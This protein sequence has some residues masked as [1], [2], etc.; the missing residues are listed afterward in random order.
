MEKAQ[1]SKSSPNKMENA[2]I[3]LYYDARAFPEI[4]RK[5]LDMLRQYCKRRKYK[6]VRESVRKDLGMFSGSVELLSLTSS[7]P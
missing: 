6:I 2:A 3:V 4:M 5:R 1:K 7:S